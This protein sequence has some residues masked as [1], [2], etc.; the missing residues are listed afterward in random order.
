MFAYI[1]PL[2]DTLVVEID[3]SEILSLHGQ[4]V[5][6]H[7]EISLDTLLSILE[8]VNAGTDLSRFEP[9]CETCDGTATNHS[10]WCDMKLTDADVIPYANQGTPA[11]VPFTDIPIRPIH[12]QINKPTFR[13]HGEEIDWTLKNQKEDS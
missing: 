6:N 7:P 9:P 11:P 1:K 12:R 3:R 5:T 8:A 4:I 13:N 2:T 10:D